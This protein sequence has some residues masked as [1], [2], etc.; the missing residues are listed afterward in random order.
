MCVVVCCRVVRIEGILRVIG[1]DTADPER[2]QRA[3]A[4]IAKLKA[5]LAELQAGEGLLSEQVCSLNHSQCSY[6]ISL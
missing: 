2:V 6:Y 3:E 4:S 5:Q 1:A